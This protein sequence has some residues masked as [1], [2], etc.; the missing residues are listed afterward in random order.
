MA[1]AGLL[2]PHLSRKRFERR[3]GTNFAGAGWRSGDAVLSTGRDLSTVKWDDL[4]WS[5]VDVN[6][7]DWDNFTMNDLF[8]LLLGGGAGGETI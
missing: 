8:R 5:R 2:Y 3:R 1:G 7:I 4:D 6:A